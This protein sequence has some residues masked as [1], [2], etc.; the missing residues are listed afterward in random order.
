MSQQTELAMP[1]GVNL[2]QET[3]RTFLISERPLF[4][5]ALTVALEE[6]PG[7]AVVGHANALEVAGALTRM[8]S[9]DFQVLLL[10]AASDCSNTLVTARGI[11]KAL[12]SVK[13]LIL[14][15]EPSE[16]SV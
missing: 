5:E 3:I 12:P 16:E 14:G 6:V 13:L 1:E 4:A 9:M 7:L 10:E 15:S 8:K 11:K 2:S